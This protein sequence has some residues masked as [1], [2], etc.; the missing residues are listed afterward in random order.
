MTHSSSNAAN[1]PLWPLVVTL[2]DVFVPEIVAQALEA[3]EQ[4]DEKYL[5]AV[6]A[7]VARDAEA[8]LSLN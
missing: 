5:R 1:L 3:C 8:G 7:R 2:E 6:I 4:F